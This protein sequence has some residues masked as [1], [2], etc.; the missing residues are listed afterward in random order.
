[1]EATIE[2]VKFVTETD[3]AVIVNGG[4]VNARGDGVVAASFDLTTKYADVAAHTS[5]END[6]PGIMLGDKNAIHIN[7]DRKKVMTHIVFP[8]YAGWN[9]HCADIG[10]YTLSI[11]FVKRDKS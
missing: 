3:G 9:I 11:C 6:V 8:Q 4:Y 1:M 10:R 2:E 5:D 7:E